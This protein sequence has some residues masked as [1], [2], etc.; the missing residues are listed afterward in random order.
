[1]SVNILP[2]QFIS[3]A[4]GDRLD[5]LRR[6]RPCTASTSQPLEPAET[7]CS[8]CIAGSYHPNLARVRPSHWQYGPTSRRT[9]IDKVDTGG[10]NAHPV[11]EVK[12]M[13]G[14]LRNRSQHTAPGVLR[15]TFA[16][17]RYPE[18]CTLARTHHLADNPSTPEALPPFLP[19]CLVGRSPRKVDVVLLGAEFYEPPLPTL[20]SK[21]SNRGR[22][23]RGGGR[24]GHFCIPL[25]ISYKCL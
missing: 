24:R 25:G 19:A 15:G 1:M 11:P 22:C 6:R 14:Y 3:F 13:A 8:T 18:A 16:I 7:K 10:R 20:R 12:E 23:C 4:T 17:T 9:L 21:P 5:V 2:P